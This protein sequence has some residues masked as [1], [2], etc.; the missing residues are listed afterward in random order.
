MDAV[1][2][3]KPFFKSKDWELA[4]N[5]RTLAG[6]QTARNNY[7]SLLRQH[8]VLFLRHGTPVLLSQ[9]DAVQPA[10]VLPAPVVVHVSDDTT[11][12]SDELKK[13]NDKSQ[14]RQKRKAD[15]AAAAAAADSSFIRCSCSGY[16][17]ACKA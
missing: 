14:K 3:L 2:Y 4:A 15:V 10:R 5:K 7:S 12:Q 1:F 6:C 9:P 16:C 17:Y 11:D 8:C 13:K